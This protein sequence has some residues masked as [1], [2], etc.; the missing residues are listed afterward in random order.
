VAK[1][2]KKTRKIELEHNFDRLA[3]RKIIQAYELLVPD[4]R[5]ETGEVIERVDAKEKDQRYEGSFDLC[6]GF[7]G[8]A[9]GRRYHR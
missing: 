3:A 9:K 4:R 5:R 7:F 6:A 8:S 1:A 2:H